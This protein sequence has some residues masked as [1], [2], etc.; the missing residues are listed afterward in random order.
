MTKYGMV[1]DATLCMGCDACFMACKDEFVGNDYPPYTA[2][3]PETQY[4][5]YPGHELGTGGALY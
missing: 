1:I 2:A 4:G 5:Y 3:Q